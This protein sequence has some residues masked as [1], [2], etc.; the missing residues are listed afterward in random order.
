MTVRALAKLTA[1][2]TMCAASLT[3]AAAE[4]KS[5]AITLSSQVRSAIVDFE[6]VNWPLRGRVEV[7]LTPAQQA[8]TV[9]VMPVPATT[10]TPPGYIVTAQGTGRVALDLELGDAEIR[11]HGRRWQVVVGT[12]QHA[13]A[14][15]LVSGRVTVSDGPAAGAQPLAVVPFDPPP[16]RLAQPL[17]PPAPPP[18]AAPPPASGSAG[19]V[20]PPPQPGAGVAPP[21]P[22]PASAPAAAPPPASGSVGYVPP[23]PRPGAGG[24]APPPPPPVSAPAAARFRVTLDGFT[25]VRETW[26]TI[27]QTDGKGDE[28]FIVADVQVFDRERAHPPQRIK[29]PTY[30][31]TNG[32][33]QRI[34]AGRGADPGGGIAG[35]GILSGA[36]NGGGNIS[37]IRTGDSVPIANPWTRPA[38]MLTRDRLPLV[39]WE[40]WLTEG[41]TSVVIVPTVW[42]EDNGD[43]LA[44]GYAAATGAVGSL[45]RP[46][47]EARKLMPHEQFARMLRENAQGAPAAA[48]ADVL[49]ALNPVNWVAHIGNWIGKNV[50]W[51][52][53]QAGDR[54]IGQTFDQRRDQYVFMPK[55]L[56]LDYRSA[57]RLAA[58][59]QPALSPAAQA[60]LPPFM[61][62]ASAV[63]LPPGVISMLYEDDDRLAGR[64][65][66]WLRVERLQ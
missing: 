31:D 20:P 55:V 22:A 19:Y 38:S 28:I 34:R 35:A 3:V 29:T 10:A 60:A 61:R 66:L 58:Q 4:L 54:P 64:Y 27:L 65:L 37:G 59:Q 33:P 17:L 13:L 57:A 62:Q 36:A 47:D 40:G 21:P 7:T 43:W 46:F 49:Q 50:T 53:G 18:A 1:I 23:P 14:A 8:F 44:G 30:G 42:E 63:Q 32:F 2:A 12:S 24:A 16:K 11:V 25:A 15:P 5:A 39:L 6:V 9:Q 26:D 52:V 45:L 51:V 56:N 41:V 48:M